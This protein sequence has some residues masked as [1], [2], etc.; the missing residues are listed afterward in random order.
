MRRKTSALD[1]SWNLH[2]VTMKNCRGMTKEEIDNVLKMKEYG[3]LYLNFQVIV[4][5]QYFIIY[6]IK[7]YS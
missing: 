6:D 7:F 1:G 4:K 5:Q 2:S 3:A